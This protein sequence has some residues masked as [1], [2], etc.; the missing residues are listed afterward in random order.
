MADLRRGAC[1]PGARPLRDAIA[2]TRAHDPAACSAGATAWRRALR[3]TLPTPIHRP[4]SAFRSAWALTIPDKPASDRGAVQPR[5]VRAVHH[6]RLGGDA[7]AT[8][9]ARRQ[10]DDVL[11]PREDF[12][13]LS[14]RRS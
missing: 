2:R 8:R 12:T 6:A 9:L 10:I 11:G 14:R 1:A 4:G 13:V 7:L 3:S 5:A